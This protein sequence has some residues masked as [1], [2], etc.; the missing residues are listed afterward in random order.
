MANTAFRAAD[1]HPRWLGGVLESTLRMDNILFALET[2][3]KILI[4]VDTHEHV[5]QRSV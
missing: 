4:I 5:G 1:A 3:E 2:V